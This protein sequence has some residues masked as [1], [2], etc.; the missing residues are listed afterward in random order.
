MWS[1]R[2]GA[3]GCSP[4]LRVV[5]GAGCSRSGR[6]SLLWSWR[7][8]W[9]GRG[10]SVRRDAAEDGF[11]KIG[12]PVAI[13]VRDG[14]STFASP[15]PWPGSEVLVVVSA[16]A[17]SRGPFPIQLTARQ[18]NEL[19]APVRTGRRRS[20]A[21]ASGP[22]RRAHSRRL[23]EAITRRPPPMERPFHMLVRDGDA[24]SPSNYTA[25]SRCAQGSRAQSPGLRRRGR[26]RTGLRRPGP[27]S[28]RHV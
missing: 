21:A 20:A 25:D 13:A 2:R 11:W 24:G 17:R 12:K 9:V 14:R 4:S 16:L 19:T 10:S 5:T 8:G 26:R 18:A 28:H 27:G 6:R 1:H 23:T 15:T 22:P 7:A 3:T